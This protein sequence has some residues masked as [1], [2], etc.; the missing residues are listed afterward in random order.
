M[1][2]VRSR[3]DARRAELTADM[4]QLARKRDLVVLVADDAR[5]AALA[6]GLHLP[7]ARVWE[8]VHWRALHPRWRITAAMHGLRLVPAGLD[9]VF[10]SPVFPTR[11]HPGRSALSAMRANA[12]A[13]AMTVPVYALGGVDARNAVLLRGFAG[14]GA[15]GALADSFPCQS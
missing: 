8:S 13:G 14:I 6:G 1:V 9:A 7:E 4:L 12:I 10:L 3:D 5:L 15:I 2:I 11:S